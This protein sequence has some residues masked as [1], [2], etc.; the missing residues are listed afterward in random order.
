[1]KTYRGI[2]EPLCHVRV[3]EDPDGAGVP[4]R[5]GTRNLTGGR[6]LAVPKE[7]VSQVLAPLDWGVEGQGPHYLAVALLAD[8]LGA[9]DRA[10]IKAALP[11][12]RRFL[13][14]LP[15]DDFEIAETIFRAMIETIN[16][17]NGGA[18][19]PPG[20]ADAGGVAPS[21]RES[22]PREGGLRG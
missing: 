12:M 22:A 1:V 15:K 6:V 18:P 11:F 10:G 19:A 8:V 13:S 14:R 2:R 20:K 5:G 3:F 21:Q 16:P 9:A 17:S 7:L 4:V